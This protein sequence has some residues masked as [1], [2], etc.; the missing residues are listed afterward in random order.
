MWP[1][2]LI[3]RGGRGTLRAE[4]PGRVDRLGALTDLEVELRARDAARA[5]D[6]GDHLTG[7]NGKF[8]APAG[9]HSG[10]NLPHAQSEGCHNPPYIGPGGLSDAVNMAWCGAYGV[11]R[12]TAPNAMR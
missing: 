6:A 2:G 4:Q 8:S 5:S 11:G 3:Q 7:V 1:G 9:M 10:P 12:L